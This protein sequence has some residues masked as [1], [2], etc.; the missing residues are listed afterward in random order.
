M[1]SRIKPLSIAVCPGCSGVVGLSLSIVIHVLL[2]VPL[3]YT[4]HVLFV[5]FTTVYISQS[6]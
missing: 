4:Y 6:Y 3:R 1:K 2:L 5:Y